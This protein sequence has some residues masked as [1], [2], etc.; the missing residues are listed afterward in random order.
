MQQRLGCA[1]S[2]EQAHAPHP[3]PHTPA[4]L[5]KASPVPAPYDQGAHVQVVGQHSV[6]FFFLHGNFFN[7]SIGK[8]LPI[9]N[10]TYVV[11]HRQI[12]IWMTMVIWNH[13]W[14]LAGLA[15]G[16]CSYDSHDLVVGW[17]RE[18]QQ[19][20]TANNWERWWKEVKRRF[21][22]VYVV[23]VLWIQVTL[24]TVLSGWWEGSKRLKTYSAPRFGH[25]L[26]LL[27][28]E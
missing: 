3:V 1:S 19:N 8:L 18:T 12:V 24:L 28:S 16:A 2:T 26:L 21:R 22:T 23:I 9:R 11:R 5:L 4:P 13:L 10:K 7:Y 27:W 25:F 17:G 6:R 14:L 15:F 20:P